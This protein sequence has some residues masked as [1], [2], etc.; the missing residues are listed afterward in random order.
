MDINFNGGYS[1]ILSKPYP[2]NLLQEEGYNEV[3]WQPGNLT[4]IV[5]LRSLILEYFWNFS[6][7]LFGPLLH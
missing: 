5:S 3:Q 2:S 7:P 1:E 4:M 6:I